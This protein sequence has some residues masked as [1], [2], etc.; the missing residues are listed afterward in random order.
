VSAEPESTLEGWAPEIH[1]TAQLA[2]VIDL[3]FDYRGDVTLTPI[4]GAVLTGYLYNR[5]RAGPEPFVQV[6]DGTGG[7]HTF[8]YAE[9]RAIAFTGKDTAAG[10]SWEAWRQRKAES[11]AKPGA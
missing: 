7:S 1:D 4:H 2:E 5:N 3:A 8:R 10:K 9:I 6:F 11:A